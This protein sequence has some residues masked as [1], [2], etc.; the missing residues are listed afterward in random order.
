M[1]VL[2][3]FLE[4]L[5][6]GSV[7]NHFT[8][9]MGELIKKAREEAGLSQRELS[10]LIYRRQAALSE[11]ENGLMQ[12]DAGTLFILSSILKKPITY[13]YPAPFKLDHQTE[14]LSEM[15][16]ELI[17]QVEQLSEDDLKRIIAQVKALVS[18]NKNN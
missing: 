8:K 4:S 5:N 1:N 10:S 6:K 17:I 3:Q 15:E 2:E 14:E 13:F 11:M 12:P 7:P 9:G 16:K 18:L